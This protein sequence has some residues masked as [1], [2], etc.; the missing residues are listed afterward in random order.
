[1]PHSSV[2]TNARTASA[3]VAGTLL[4][5]SRPMSPPT[6]CSPQSDDSATRM[7]G[8]TSGCDQPLRPPSD[9]LA[10]EDTGAPLSQRPSHV[11]EESLHA[12]VFRGLL[13]W[14]YFWPHPSKS[15]TSRS[16]GSR[17]S[18]EAPGPTAQ[19]RRSARA[20]SREG[21]GCPAACPYV[22]TE[23]PPLVRHL[24]GFARRQ[25]S[26]HMEWSRAQDRGMEGE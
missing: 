8:E 12:P 7:R 1:M 3:R 9:G 25:S 14:G 5:Q 13:H 17:R 24:P 16:W 21:H 6:L 4:R 10:A 11:R 18:G 22:P 26:G 2:G 19:V 20:T 23:H 15:A